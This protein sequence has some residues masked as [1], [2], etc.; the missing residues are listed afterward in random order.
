MD[1]SL[2]GSP[3]HVILQARILEWIHSLLQG[4]FL[5]QGSNPGLLHYRQILYHLSYQG[6]LTMKYYSALKRR[7]F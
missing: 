5:T 3:I 4:M 1:C 6:S 7:T 2:S